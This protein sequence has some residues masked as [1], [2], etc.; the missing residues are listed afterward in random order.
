[1]EVEEFGTVIRVRDLNRCRIFYQ[2]LLE[3]DEPEINSTFLVRFRLA[4]KTVLYLEKCDAP[5]LEHASAAS[6]F[7][8]KVKEL[9]ILIVLL[10]LIPRLHLVGR[11]VFG[12]LLAIL[13]KITAVVGY[14]CC[15]LCHERH[16][17]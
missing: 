7:T 4:P 17:A 15:S 2:R 1:M 12:P 13:N 3:L 16:H 9:V 14:K 5:Y 10:V 6:A 8:F 11:A